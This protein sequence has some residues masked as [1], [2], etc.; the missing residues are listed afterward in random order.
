[1]ETFAAVSIG[2]PVTLIE[3]LAPGGE[4]A[5][6]LGRIGPA[7]TAAC[8]LGGSL[9]TGVATWAEE[10]SYPSATQLTFAA[11]FLIGLLVRLITRWSRAANWS[12]RHRLALA[13]GAL[14]TA[15]W[16]ALLVGRFTGQ[17]DSLSQLGPVLFA[18]L[19]G[20]VQVWGERRTRERPRPAVIMLA[21]P[22]RP[23][24]AGKRA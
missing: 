9:I 21:P 11:V 4:G 22:M 8:H 5:P 10:H 1:M 16:G 12:V 2:V 18:L 3:A 7:V 14:F 19:I 24:A 20:A 6:W 17:T 15:S 23:P 13:A